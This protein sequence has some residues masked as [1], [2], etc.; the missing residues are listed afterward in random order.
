MLPI[1]LLRF[2]CYVII[3][4]LN[5]LQKVALELPFYRTY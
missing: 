5:K 1:L 2:Y 4:A 3:A